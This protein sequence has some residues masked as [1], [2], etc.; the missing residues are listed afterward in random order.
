MNYLLD[1]DT[2]LWFISDDPALS[3]P[4]KSL[5]EHP[6]HTIRLRVASIWEMAIKA[7]LG[8]LMVPSPFTDFVNEQ[9]SAN[10][11]QLLDINT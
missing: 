7:S 8:R 2:F 10:T 3:T 6:D 1:T 4:A 11:I 9:L 5:I